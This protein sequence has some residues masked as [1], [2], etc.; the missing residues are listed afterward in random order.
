MGCTSSDQKGP[1]IVVT[2]DDPFDQIVEA[3]E[4]V[5]QEEEKTQE[6]TINKYR[7]EKTSQAISRYS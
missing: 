4:K 1:N 3:A 5:Q 6:A 7:K 2:K